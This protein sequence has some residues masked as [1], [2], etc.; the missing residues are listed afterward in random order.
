[1]ALIGEDDADLTVMAHT[2][3]N[4]TAVV[5]TDDISPADAHVAGLLH[6]AVRLADIAVT[7]MAFKPVPSAMT[8]MIADNNSAA[9]A[10][11]GKLE[12]DTACVGGR[13]GSCDAGSGDNDGGE[14]IADEGVHGC[15]PDLAAF[16]ALCVSLISILSR[17]VVPFD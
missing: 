13:G 2:L 3:D 6:C 15:S 5:D 9:G 1:V 16:H 11:E 4:D 8:A 12:A 7:T 17:P 14:C 10:A